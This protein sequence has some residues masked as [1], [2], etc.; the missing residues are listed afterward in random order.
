LFNFINST[1]FA[2]NLKR[3]FFFF[4][5][6]ICFIFK[7][8]GQNVSLY[9]QFNGRYDFTFIGNTMN[10]TEN[11]TTFDLVTTTS[12]SATLS[13]N[14][15]DVIEK[16]YLYWA[17]S[18][19][20]DFEVNLNSEVITPDRTFSLVREFPGLTL[21][22]FSAF[23]DVTSLIQTTGNGDYTLSN[24]DISQFEEFHFQRRTNFAGWAI[25]I[26]YKN[27]TLPLNQINVYDGL[28]GVPDEL[29]I[30]LSSL[31][32]IDDN[33]SKVGFVAWEGDS[34]LATEEFRMNGTLLSSASNP[35]NNVFNGTNSITGSSTLY[36]M[37]LDIYEIQNNIAV[38][39]TSAEITLT[40]FQDFVMINTVVTKLN[41]QLP[42]ATVS[43][44]SVEKQC[45]SKT[46]VVNYT[47]S[48]L[49]STNP[50]PAATPISIYIDGQLFQTIA[51][52]VEIPIGGSITGQITLN[53]PDT[54]TLDFEIKF[55]V[56]DIGNGT[57]IVAELVENNN[58][59]IANDSLWISPT[60]N[61]LENL[62]VCNEGFTRGTFDFSS[63]EDL[64]KI[65]PEDSVRFYE[66][67]ENA[68]LDVNPILNTTN[69][70][71]MQTP[72]E[73]FIR[74]FDQNCFSITSFLLTTR[75]CPPTVYNVVSAN[76]DSY[77]DNFTI[78]GLRDIFLDFKLEIYSRWG[79]LIWT[80]NQNTEDWNG[81]VKDGIGSKNAS[82]GTYFY[83]LF[84]NDIDYPEPLSGFLYLNH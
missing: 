63:Y 84:L 10:T 11:N 83:L 54:V 43:I 70:Q 62:L 41:S 34:G 6:L 20:G 66:T 9:N 57:G 74:V 78:G 79:R 28:Q 61:P 67:L 64:V 80:G 8:N 56:D 7:T 14:S 37:D 55:M 35:P 49:N 33:N 31:N 30:T 1:V 5:V 2:L 71:A 68:T 29:S 12:S 23:K 21:T 27:D 48:N 81:Y 13:L 50:L 73:I 25:V 76:N 82:D 16:A 60:F 36:N 46:I 39:D 24:L 58:T 69:Y 59:A 53:L 65:N 42:D 40:S 3:L 17:G 19:D 38:G 4:I 18:G 45:D 26:I 72:K 47:V 15:S 75:N 44:D 51:T 22:Y 77:N 32:V 52:S